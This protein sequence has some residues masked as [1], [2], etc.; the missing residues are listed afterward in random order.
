MSS[1]LD[2]STTIGVGA[3][4]A[5]KIE[6]FLSDRDGASELRVRE[7]YSEI[8]QRL[9][10]LFSVRIELNCPTHHPNAQGEWIVLTGSS[11]DDLQRAKV[12][13]EREREELIFYF[14]SYARQSPPSVTTK[15]KCTVTVGRLAALV[16]C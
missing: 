6:F 13:E 3:R 2:T 5:I 16:V 12:G 14:N 8:S 10:S 11:K 15:Q 1:G 7:A 4:G 9:R